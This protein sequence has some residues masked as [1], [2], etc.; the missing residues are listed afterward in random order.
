MSEPSTFTI[1]AR[2]PS[3]RVKGKILRARIP[4][5]EESLSPGPQGS[6]AQVIDYDASSRTL[7][8]PDLEPHLDR[9]AAAS[10]RALLSNPNFHA[11]N[12]FAIAMRTLARFEQ[13]LGRH[14]GW[15]FPSHQIKIAP[16]AFLDANAF[17]S[18]PNEALLFGYFP[19]L[20]SRGTVFSCLSHDVVAHETAHAVLD[21]IRG[22]YVEP[23]G[24][25][26]AAFH[27]GFA[28]LVALLSVLSLPQVVDAALAR[29]RSRGKWRWKDPSL[30]RVAREVGI[31][32]G[33]SPALRRPADLR[34]SRRL[35]GRRAF[36]DPHRRG[37]VLVA[38]VLRAYLD[39]W[40]EQ[41]SGSIRR[42]QAIDSAAL[43]ADHLLTSLIR[44]L[45][46][47][48]PVN[49][50]FGDFLSGLLT[51]NLEHSGAQTKALRD[52]LRRNFGRFGIVPT[53]P[54]AIPEPGV[55]AMAPGDLRAAVPAESLNRNKHEVFRFL[56]NNRAMLGINDE[57]HIKVESVNPAR[58]LDSRGF[59]VREVV[60]EYV[61]TLQV[62][63][64]ELVWMSP[65][66]VKP[67][68]M[69]DSQ[70]VTLTGGGTLIFDEH[71]R[72]KFDIRCSLRDAARQSARLRH[73]WEAG[74]FDQPPNGE[75]DS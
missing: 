23:A 40:C 65:P 55:W 50:T 68:G 48:P 58:K 17:Y 38:A 10:D 22:R 46:Y 13:A 44:A 26:Q 35:L 18:K 66:I 39:R 75:S 36:Q 60:A 62:R 51:A 32:S 74:Y 52:A 59:V 8:Q 11:Q 56:W 19:A 7:Y 4:V 5:P 31:E 49:L 20:R 3:V 61:K 47:C 15:G 57:A 67:E 45:D 37:E 29:G 41:S 34:P 53:S 16:H 54:A 24:P 70:M 14:V 33:G 30:F 2:D 9:F 69:P 1:V 12:A 73:L 63:A 25:D 21:G 42:S 28:D 64:A 71:S 6:R 72:L 43:L 27:E